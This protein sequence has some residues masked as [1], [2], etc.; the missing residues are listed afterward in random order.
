MVTVSGKLPP[1]ATAAPT[2]DLPCCAAERKPLPHEVGQRA[3]QRGN[4]SQDHVVGER[5]VIQ[6]WPIHWGAAQKCDLQG[7]RWQ[8][9]FTLRLDLLVIETS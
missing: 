1:Y 2:A 5:E 9:N 6:I 8:L 3:R 7:E 4:I